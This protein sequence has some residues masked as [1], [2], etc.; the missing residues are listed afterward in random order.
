MQNEK[1]AHDSTPLQTD[2]LEKEAY[3]TPQIVPLGDG[4][5]LIQSQSRGPHVDGDSDPNFRF[6]PD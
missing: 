5:Q 4:A 1:M 3:Q 6:K 2:G